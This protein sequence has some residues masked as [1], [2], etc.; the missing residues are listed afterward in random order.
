MKK[1]ALTALLL[2]AACL[3][4]GMFPT[5]LANLAQAIAAALML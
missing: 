4:I 3:L 5:A 1:A 2:A